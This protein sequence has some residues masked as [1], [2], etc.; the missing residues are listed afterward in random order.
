MEGD[1]QDSLQQ[2]QKK[3]FGKW[4][5]FQLASSAGGGQKGKASS[6]PKVTDLYYDLRDGHILLDVLQILTGTKERHL[7]EGQRFSGIPAEYSRICWTS[8]MLYQA[9]FGHFSANSTQLNSSCMLV[10]EVFF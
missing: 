3:T 8:K 10:F 9:F 1:D 2:V 6:T 5:N 4:I 7:L